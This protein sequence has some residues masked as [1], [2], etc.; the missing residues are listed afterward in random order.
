MVMDMANLHPNLHHMFKAY[1][2]WTWPFEPYYVEN[3]TRD[4]DTEWVQQLFEA[5]DPYSFF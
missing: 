5:C 2:G 3:I 1:G 4:L